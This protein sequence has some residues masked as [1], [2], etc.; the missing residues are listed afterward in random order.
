L[1]RL[2]VRT[3]LGVFLRNGVF[4]MIGAVVGTATSAVLVADFP[5]ERILLLLHDW[6]AGNR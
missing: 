6:L 3:P 4:R 5:V 1:L 2:F